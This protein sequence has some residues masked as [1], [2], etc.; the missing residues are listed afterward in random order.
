MLMIRRGLRHVFEKAPTWWTGFLLIKKLKFVSAAQVGKTAIVGKENCFKMLFFFFFFNMNVLRAPLHFTSESLQYLY[1]EAAEWNMH[2]SRRLR[3]TICLS[4]SSSMRLIH[5]ATWNYLC[6]KFS[7]SV[8]D[9]RDDNLEQFHRRNQKTRPCLYSRIQ[10]ESR[11]W[12]VLNVLPV[13]LQQIQSC[14]VR[15][16]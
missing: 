12:R 13:N 2:F 9:L 11:Q 10:K 3:P 15:N 6:L 7:E 8:S 4:V 14:N 1:T 16:H 5:I